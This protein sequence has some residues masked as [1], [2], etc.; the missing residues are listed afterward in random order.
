[1]SPDLQA[2]IAV[3][4]QRAAEG[5]LTA[6]EEK[7]AIAALRAERVS[8]AHASEGARRKKAIAVIPSS[9]D[10]LAEALGG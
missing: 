6:L 4:R 2:K 10:L 8:A 3:W 9:D 1:M 5:T 7:E